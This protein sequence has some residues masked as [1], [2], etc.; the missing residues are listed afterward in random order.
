MGTGT[1]LAATFG[2]SSG[3]LADGRPERAAEGGIAAAL[4]GLE[5]AHSE[6]L[7]VPVRLGVFAFGPAHG[8]APITH[9]ASELFPMCSTFK[10]LAVAAV[11]QGL[12]KGDR[13]LDERVRYTERDTDSSG[14]APIT[15]KPENLRRGMTGAELC[16]AA[17]SYSD[18]CAANLLLRRLGGPGAVTRFC[19]SVGD[20]DTRLDRWEP[21]LNSAEPG[22]EEDTTTPRA[23]ALTYSRL[24]LG[25]VLPARHKRRLTDWLLGNT[26]SGKQFRAGLPADWE[27]GD[28]TGAGK[29]GTNN[30]VGVAWP[31]GRQPVV[32]AVLTTT[33][34]RELAKTKTDALIAETAALIAGELG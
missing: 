16:G 33:G 26:T 29:Y 8:G 23:I 9:R 30:D 6:R 12:R 15:G 24:V 21:E 4:H 27:I 18:N 32:L 1:A 34:D 13:F 28:K 11:L 19:R 20:D 3:A 31:P 5:A 10:T 2:S 25:N 17:I 14:Y 22:R 7:D